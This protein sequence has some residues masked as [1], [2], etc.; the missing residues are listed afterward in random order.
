V[1]GGGWGGGGRGIR[2][3][4]RASDHSSPSQAEVKNT[5]RPRLLRVPYGILFHSV[6]GKR[7]PS[8][9]QLLCYFSRSVA[10]VL[11]RRPGFDPGYV[12]LEF[13][14]EKLALAREFIRLLRF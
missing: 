6:Q 12:Y 14:V 9:L 5:R 7:R 8:S 4:Y 11:P 2:W 10:C 13:M 3:S 1:G